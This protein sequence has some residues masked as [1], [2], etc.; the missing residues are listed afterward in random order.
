MAD[1]GLIDVSILGTTENASR[2]CVLAEELKLEMI[3]F[4]VLLVGQ[5]ERDE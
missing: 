3:Y 4:V 1:E 2:R 5:L